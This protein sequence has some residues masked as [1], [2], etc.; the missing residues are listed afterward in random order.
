VPYVV[1]ATGLTVALALP[2]AYVVTNFGT[3]FRLRLMVAAVLWCLPLALSMPR[4]TVRARAAG[5]A[6]SADAP[7]SAGLSV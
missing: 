6:R 7:P 3:L 2:M 4:A 1:F 5:P